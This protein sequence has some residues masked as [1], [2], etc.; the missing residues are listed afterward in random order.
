MQL[1]GLGPL[2][3][4]L[5]SKHYNLQ[6]GRGGE[7]GGG[8]GDAKEGTNSGVGPHVQVRGG[9]G[10][11]RAYSPSTTTCRLAG[12]RGRGTCGGGRERGRRRGSRQC[13]LHG[14]LKGGTGQQGPHLRLLRLGGGRRVGSA[15]TRCYPL[16]SQ[17]SQDY[18]STEHAGC[19]HGFQCTAAAARALPT[20]PLVPQLTFPLPR[21]FSLPYPESQHN[22]AFALYGL[23]E[24]EDNIPD[25]IREGALQ[26][27]EDCK[28][29]LQV[30]VR[31]TSMS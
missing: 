29:K 14:Q 28:E 12:E 19:K 26:R 5:E 27:L 4:L 3:E 22:A 25:L 24:N 6:V 30:Q 20:G 11:T 2:L 17:V 16:E 10:A 9:M 13:S 15:A 21:P 23:A 1:G 31:L 8:L 7:G 18:S